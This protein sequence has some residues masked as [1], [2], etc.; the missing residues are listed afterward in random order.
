MA[1]AVI[2]KIRINRMIDQCDACKKLHVCA[3]SSVATILFDLRFFPFFAFFSFFFWRCFISI[4]RARLVFVWGF[5]FLTW[6]CKTQRR[7]RT[8]T[9]SPSFPCRKLRPR[10]LLRCAADWHGSR[11]AICFMK[12][13]QTQISTSNSNELI[14]R[15]DC[16]CWQL[17]K[18]LSSVAAYIKDFELSPSNKTCNF[19]FWVIKKLLSWKIDSINLLR[20][21]RHPDWR[22]S[23][24]TKFIFPAKLF[25]IKAFRYHV[26]NIKLFKIIRT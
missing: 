16:E 20:I 7:A 5:G 12:K 19:F 24:E 17:L 23:L 6:D 13:I 25:S 11:S 14:V 2:I 9:Q 4:G 26:K 10:T 3:R 15:L 22:R 1:L 21:S 18:L 8:P